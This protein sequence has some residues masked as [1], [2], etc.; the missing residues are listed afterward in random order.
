MSEPLELRLPSGRSLDAVSAGEHQMYVQ[1]ALAAAVVDQP[2]GLV[3]PSLE[4]LAGRFGLNR[5]TAW[6]L[7][8]T[9]VHTGHLVQLGHIYVT[10]H[11]KPG[12]EIGHAG[13]ATP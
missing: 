11:P 2:E 12:N 9:L 7:R 1:I 10:A 3:L 13:G 8:S 5:E 4:R 6:R